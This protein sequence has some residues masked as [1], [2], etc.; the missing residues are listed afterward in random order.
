MALLALLS[1]ALVD[2]APLAWPVPVLALL[3]AAA[4]LNAAAA[5]GEM[6]DTCTLVSPE[7]LESGGDCLIGGA[8]EVGVGSGVDRIE[9]KEVKRGRI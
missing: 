3:S 8:E 4:L 5:P 6:P 7:E 2:L 9:V 1:N